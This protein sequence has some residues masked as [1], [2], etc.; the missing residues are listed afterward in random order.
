MPRLYFAIPG[1]LDQRTGG[2][3]YDRRVIEALREDGWR[4]VLEKLGES[5]AA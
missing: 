2:T 3:L 5:L 1:P 4:K